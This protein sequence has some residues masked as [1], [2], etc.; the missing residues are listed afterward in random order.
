LGIGKLLFFAFKVFLFL[1]VHSAS[2]R[3]ASL[4]EATREANLHGQAIPNESD[5]ME[6]ARKR[7]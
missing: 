3:R 5:F 6:A 2:C 4:S 7:R 1:A